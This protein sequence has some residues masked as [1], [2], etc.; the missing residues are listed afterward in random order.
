MYTTSHSARLLCG[1]LSLGFYLLTFYAN[2]QNITGKW[3]GT[4]SSHTKLEGALGESDLWID[5]TITNN[6]A[7][8]IVRKT[9]VMRINGQEVCKEQCYGVGKAQLYEVSFDRSGRTYRVHSISPAFTCRQIGSLCEF[10]EP[11]E[12]H[13]QD[14]LPEDQPY[15][16][17]Q[18]LNLLTGSQTRVSNI[19]PTDKVTTTVSWSLIQGPLDAVL[20]V[21]PDNYN[22]WW[23]RATADE[24]RKGTVIDINM[25]LQSRNGGN[26]PFKV[27]RFELKL[28]NTSSE[29]GTT[30]NMPVDPRCSSFQTFAFFLTGLEKA[31]KPISPSK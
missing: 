22:N 28:E 9:S 14:V 2:A 7:Q 21:T 6:Q 15:Q 1:I 8:G 4:M 17:D 25:K 24:L 30:L 26:S 20:I 23:P 27:A 13:S 18:N 12:M 5:I 31:S 10:P 19:T 3:S 11:H 29:S 16:P